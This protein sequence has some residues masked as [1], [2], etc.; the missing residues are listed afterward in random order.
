MS[1]HYYFC[2]LILRCEREDSMRDQLTDTKHM[3]SVYPLST[4]REE[5]LCGWGRYPYV[6]TLGVRPKSKDELKE[7]LADTIRQGAHALAYGHGRSY[8]DSGLPGLNT[9]VI[10][11][12]HLNRILH[13]DHE[14][15]W[16]RCEAGVSIYE[17]IQTFV[18]K[19]F[20][21]PVVPGT[22]FV[23]V[24]GAISNDIHGKNH[25]VDGTFTD[26]VRRIEILT[27]DGEIIVCDSTHYP[28][29][30]W[31]TVG[32]LGLTGLILS[33]E[34]KLMKID[35]PGIAMESIKVKNLDHFF[36]V[37]A[38]SGEF[39]HTV[40]WIDCVAKGAS[41]GRGIFMR[42]RHTHEQPK[43]RAIGRLAQAVS[44]LLTV[45]VS[46]PNFLLN[47][48]TIK[49]FNALYYGK[50]P[51]KDLA[52]VVNYEP[53]FFPLD[54]VRGWNKIYGKRGFLQYQM[55][56]PKTPD[57]KAIRSILDEITKTGM[58]SFLAVIKEFGNQEHGGLSFPAPGV[59][60]ALDFPNYGEALLALFN[61]L[62]RI[63]IEAGGRVYLG[64]DAR[65][66]QQHFQEMYPNWSDWKET[67]DKW[68]PKGVFRSGIGDRLGLTL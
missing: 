52:Q 45:P 20:F 6:Q 68:D 23:T 64:K 16:I 50:H 18:P 22:Q 54:F 36:E 37:S 67:R 30:F 26:H 44:P 38:E 13:F 46:M 34:L 27:G 11:T 29:L 24:A 60:L 59:T 58:G 8:G 55:V 9:R 25:H 35:G 7:C 57:H 66:P 65:L 31:A 40:S 53:F 61:R 42:G 14:T 12:R 32:G 41:L 17:L 15:G 3:Q 49:A 2:I 51:H 43:P 1:D 19:G 63:V 62:D 33:L 39:T 5:R 28:E 56:V 4:W 10:H 47:P 48:L 21:P